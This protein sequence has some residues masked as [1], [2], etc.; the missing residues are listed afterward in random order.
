VA[1]HFT[2][3]DVVLLTYSASFRSASGVMHVATHYRKSVLASAGSSALLDTVRAFGLGVVVPPDDSVA[4]AQGMAELLSQH[5]S[6]DWQAYEQA[7]S[8]DRNAQL[9]ADALGLDVG[10]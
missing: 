1:D 7:N 8:W 3:A 5:R 2:A 4:L 6:P 9:V 10:Q